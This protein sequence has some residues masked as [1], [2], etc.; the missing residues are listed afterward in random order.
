MWFQL[1]I[2]A[3]KTSFASIIMTR[4]ACPFFPLIAAVSLVRFFDIHEDDARTTCLI[5]FFSFQYLRVAGVAVMFDESWFHVIVAVSWSN[6]SR[7]LVA[8]DTSTWRRATASLRWIH[9]QTDT[10]LI[11][12]HCHRRPLR[13]RQS[14]RAMSQPCLRSNRY[15]SPRM[16][17]LTNAIAFVALHH[18]F[19]VLCAVMW[20]TDTTYT[21]CASI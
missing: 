6:I 9:A 20:C 8:Q 10:A 13:P 5:L 1:I 3:M 12:T 18:V 15:L 21:A 14:C 16:S 17:S 2:I 19:D 7:T 11:L 4:L